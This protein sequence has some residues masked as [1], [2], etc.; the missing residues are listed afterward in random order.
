MRT[1]GYVVGYDVKNGELVWTVKVKDVGNVHDGKKLLVHSLHPGTM[2]TK[3]AVDVSFDI[4]TVGKTEEIMAIDVSLGTEFPEDNATKVDNASKSMSFALVEE[5]GKVYSRY[6]ECQTQ[7]ECREWLKEQSDEC[8]LVAFL[9]INADDFAGKGKYGDY[10]DARAFFEGLQTMMKE[11]DSVSHTLSALVTEAF[12]L[13][14]DSA[15][16]E[17]GK[18]ISRLTKSK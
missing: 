12:I 14:M 18:L 8:R 5:N 11:V 15:P 13:G 6:N 10:E 2:L 3:P 4:Q 7:D 17:F 1:K 9:R 16:S